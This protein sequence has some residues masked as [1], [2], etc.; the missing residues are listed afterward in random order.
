ME[1]NQ[2]VNLSQIPNLQFFRDGVMRNALPSNSNLKWD[3]LRDY[4]GKFVVPYI[5]TG[6]YGAC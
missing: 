5:I 2:E 4:D 6:Y 1:I 3:Y